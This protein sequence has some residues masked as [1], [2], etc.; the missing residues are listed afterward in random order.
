MRHVY[1]I[2]KNEGSVFQNEISTLRIHSAHFENS[3]VMHKTSN[4]FLM[5]LLRIYALWLL[6]SHVNNTRVQNSS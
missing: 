5:Q 1:F 2:V 6:Q 3:T 4:C